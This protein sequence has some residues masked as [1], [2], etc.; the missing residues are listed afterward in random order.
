MRIVLDANVLVRAA[1]IQDSPALALLKLIRDR[2]DL[3][4]LM[5]PFLLDEVSEVLKR[6]YFKEVRGVRGE[7]VETFADALA[8]M[9]TVLSPPL[10][11]GVVASDADD[12]P[13]VSLAVTGGADFL[14]TWDKHF[15]RPEVTGLLETY[16]ITVCKDTDLLQRLRSEGE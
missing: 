4:L 14:C 9:A 3:V 16:S 11:Q 10:M 2:S 5:S 6:P 1:A 13:I 8:R 12:A 7:Q 15:Y